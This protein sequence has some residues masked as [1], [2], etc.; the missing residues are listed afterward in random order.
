MISKTEIT[1]ATLAAALALLAAPVSAEEMGGP[2]ARQ[3]KML[4]RLAQGA[5]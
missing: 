1:A 4:W 2:K 3:G 5:E